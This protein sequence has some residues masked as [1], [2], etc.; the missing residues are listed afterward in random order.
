MKRIEIVCNRSIEEDLFDR[1]KKND[2]V[3]FYT[4]IPIVFGVGTSG[5]RMGD[6]TWPEE[7]FMLIVYCD[8]KEADLI[9][10]TIEDI[11]SYFKDE[12]LK[13]FETEL[14]CCV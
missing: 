9:K 12:G 14:V 11:K 2:V 4:K 13:M 5:P 3:K 1:F 7:N 10:K 6:Q 8:E